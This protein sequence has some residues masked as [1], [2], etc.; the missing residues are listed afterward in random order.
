MYRP[1]ARLT[2]CARAAARPLQVAAS[3]CMRTPIG[4]LLLALLRL[5][6]AALVSVGMLLRLF[7]GLLGASWD[8]CRR[9]MV[10]LLGGEVVDLGDF[11]KDF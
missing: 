8:G 2:F 4:P 7:G 5:L 3:L 11:N 6:R 10:R 9:R 1:Q